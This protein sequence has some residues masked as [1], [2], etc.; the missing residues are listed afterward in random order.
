MSDLLKSSDW[1]NQPID[2]RTAIKGGVL[3]LL[4]I[5]L[6]A[7][8][9]KPDEP[10]LRAVY[11]PNG[12]VIGYVD[13]QGVFHSTGAAVTPVAGDKT[14]TP[15]PTAEPTKPIATATPRSWE[16]T[17]DLFA[18]RGIPSSVDVKSVDVAKGPFKNTIGKGTE[19]WFA[20]PGKLLVGPDFP[21][22]TIDKAGGAIE[23]FNPVNQTVFENEGPSYFNLPEG[24]FVLATGNVM[25]VKIGDTVIKLEGAP[26][27]NWMLV[28]RGRYSDGKPDSDL[29]IQM[30][31]DE[32][33]PGHLMVMRY[34]GKPNGGFISENQFKQ[35][36]KT[37]HTEGTNCG[38]D[39][40]SGLSVFMYDV[41]TGA[42]AVIE[43]FG[44]NG[45]W[46]PVWANFE[47]RK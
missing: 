13:S 16:I 24:G 35:I 29:N 36:A 28:V 31:F 44:T 27:H 26:G 22:E 7:C 5:I 39:G 1:L 9:V 32:Y 47:T 8:G 38:A 12:K 11:D 33:I 6:T 30:E 2:R 37:S 46:Q 34:P 21:Q 4:G 3:G 42:A 25:R 17:E 20:E 10:P 41:N 40:C 19:A 15:T 18:A 23:R 45:P 14:P 43:Q